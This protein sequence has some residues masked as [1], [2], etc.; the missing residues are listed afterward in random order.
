MNDLLTTLHDRF[1]F[2]D[3][4]E[5]NE[6]EIEDYYNQLKKVL[7]K[8]ERKIVLRIIDAKNRI[9]ADISLDSF[10]CG[11]RLALELAEELSYL[12][13]LNPLP[14]GRDRHTLMNAVANEQ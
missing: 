8:S 4:S 14:I 9:A 12:E 7:N 6:K 13:R 11:F 3:F 5:E 10:V 2:P 1:C